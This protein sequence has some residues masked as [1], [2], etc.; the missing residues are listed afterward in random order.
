MTFERPEFLFALAFAAFPAALYLSRYIRSR[1]QV[2]P[3]AVFLFER[4]MAP[5]HRIRGRQI[6]ITLVR[7]GLLAAIAFGFAGPSTLEE[8]GDG[9]AQV[10]QRVLFVVDVSPSMAAQSIEGSMLD[11]AV[12]E[13]ERRVAALPEGALAAVVSCPSQPGHRL[14]FLPAAEV[15]AALKELEAAPGSCQVSTLLKRLMPLLDGSA[16]VRVASDFLVPESERR[17]L[18]EMAKQEP[19]LGFVGVTGRKPNLTLRELRGEAQLYAQVQNMEEVA[20]EAV[21]TVTCGEDSTESVK[22]V[23]AG[24]AEWIPL[25]IPAGVLSGSCLV[26]LSDD[27]FAQDNQLAFVVEYRPTLGVLIL[28]GSAMTG[29]ALP[30]SHFIEAAIRSSGASVTVTVVTAAEFSVDSLASVDLVVLIDPMPLDT[31]VE[32]AFEQFFRRGGGV[33]FFAGSNLQ[34]WPD[35]GPMFREL[36]V[37]PCQAVAERPFLVEWLDK[38]S[39]WLAPISSLSPEL[40]HSWHSLNHVAMTFLDDTQRVGA[41]FS[42]GAPA[43][44]SMERWAGRMVVFSFIPDAN[45]GNIAWHPLFPVLVSSLIGEFRPDPSAIKTPPVCYQGVACGVGERGGM[46]RVYL[47]GPD[48]SLQVTANAQGS[49]SCSAPGPYIEGGRAGEPLAFVCI[50]SPGEIPGGESWSP[51]GA[52]SVA[53]EK[54]GFGEKRKEHDSLFLLLAMMLLVGEIWLVAGRYV[55]K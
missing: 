50:P 47:G 52:D 14:K 18:A 35:R 7:M 33:M 27:G 41:R 48:K 44:I 40:L 13:I 19:R 36:Q 16:Q 45:N 30:A 21:L 17:A 5:L 34:S 31:H 25:E 38:Q 54:G 42:D 46:S 2:F 9:G 51:Q 12:R 29:G 43:V 55:K 22:T 4:D 32:S 20:Q 24:G 28:E 23:P 10:A 15:G 49:L 37:R 6:G 53:A 3:A 8:T 11:Q 39:P 1:K 26:R